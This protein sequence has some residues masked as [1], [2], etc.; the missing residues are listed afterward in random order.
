MKLIKYLWG[1]LTFVEKIAIP[2]TLAAVLFTTAVLLDWF[3]KLHCPI[4]R[5][6]LQLEQDYFLDMRTGELLSAAYYF[7]EDSHVFWISQSSKLLQEAS[8]NNHCGYVR[9]PAEA[10]NTAKYCSEH[11]PPYSISQYFYI[12]S[13]RKDGM[14]CYAIPDEGT[15]TPDG[16]T[17]LKQ[18]NDTLRCWELVVLW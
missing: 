16:H 8:A 6:N 14:V 13:K 7:S 9:F 10:D 18:F 4:C 3:P 5:R 2:L 11:R 15:V 1:K 17:V 12:L